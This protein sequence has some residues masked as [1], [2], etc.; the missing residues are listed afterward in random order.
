VH[1]FIGSASWSCVWWHL[2]HEEFVGVM[3]D[4]DMVVG[5]ALFADKIIGFRIWLLVS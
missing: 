5:R 2:A 4:E 3:P 1:R